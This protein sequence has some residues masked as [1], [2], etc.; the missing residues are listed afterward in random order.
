[1]RRVELEGMQ[2]GDYITAATRIMDAAVAHGFT[3]S[4]ADPV[5]VATGNGRVTIDVP[6]ADSTRAAIGVVRAFLD[7]VP[8]AAEAFSIV[9]ADE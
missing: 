2:A 5:A 7:Q 3:V 4:L 6:N 9:T 1:M 8:G